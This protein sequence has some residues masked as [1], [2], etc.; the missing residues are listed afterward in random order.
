LVMDSFSY[1]Q[2]GRTT[3]YWQ[4]PPVNRG[5]KDIAVVYAYDLMGHPLNFFVAQNQA[6]SQGSVQDFGYDAVG[7]VTAYTQVGFTDANHPAN[8]VS[9]IGYDTMGHMN[10]A[11]F[12]NGITQTWAYNKRGFLSS[13]AAGTNC[14]AGSCATTQYGY[15]IGY[16]PNGDILTANDTVNGSWVYS[17]DP[18]NRISGAN[19]NNGQAVFSYVYDRF[20]NRWQQNGPNSMILTFTGNNTT[21]NNRIDGYCYDAAGNVLDQGACAS[22]HMFKY[23][24]ENRLISVKKGATT[25]SYDGDGRRVEKITAGNREDYIFDKDGNPI[26]NAIDTPLPYYLESYIGAWHFATYL[27][28]AAHNATTLYYHYND[29][30]GTERVRADVTG[31]NC[32]T[33]TSLPFGDAQSVLGS[34]GD[35]SPMHFTGKERDPESNLDNFGARYNSSSL[36]RFMSP[37]PKI[38]SL[39]HIINPQKWNKYAYTINNPLRY[40]DPNGMEEIEVQLRAFIP[41]KSVT[42]FGSTYAGDNRTFST[43]QNASS[44]TFIT[45][46]IETDASKSK[47]PILS[48][49]SGAGQS[50]KLD[51][52]GNVI[53]T[54]TA[55]TGLPTV[56]GTRDANGNVVLNFQ[57]DAKNPLSPGPQALT[58]GITT[59][60]NVTIPQSGSSVTAAGTTSGF[61]GIELNV[62]P[63]GQPTTNI[64]LNDPG[65]NGSPLS[66]FNTNTVFVSQPLP[67][68]P[69]P[70]AQD[71]DK[72]CQ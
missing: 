29:W 15:T 56:N 58:P 6:T 47:N 44:R 35:V 67:P 72:Q 68:P 1:D 70:C 16:A 10:A 20:G 2:L 11:A 13:M 4:C 39:R 64:P 54:A 18:L 57:Q 40:F 21:N 25:I 66:L 55:S 49:T 41:Q 59:D 37:D 28:N 17:Y 14:S 34:C 9:G 45:V 23:D 65:P 5:V 43:A 42:V 26:Q 61:P 50:G 24:A 51:S 52:N 27:V 46:K 71:K 63:D 38:L 60:L 19:K 36:G 8:L 32:E 22:P 3:Q 7:R 48:V 31:T 33:I 62:T 30:L 12:A 53:Q 69:P